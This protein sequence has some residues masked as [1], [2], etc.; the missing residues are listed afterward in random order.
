[1]DRDKST[2]TIFLSEWAFCDLVILHE[3]AH[4][5]TPQLIA[6]AGMTGVW[7]HRS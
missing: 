4:V 2:W 5:I 6:E 1:M 3:L 7:A